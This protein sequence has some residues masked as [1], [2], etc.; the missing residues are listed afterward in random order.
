M[1]KTRHS[2]LLIQ[3]EVV[4]EQK[5]VKWNQTDTVAI[6]FVLFVQLVYSACVSLTDRGAMERWLSTVGGLGVYR[7]DPCFFCRVGIGGEGSLQT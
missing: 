1:E 7:W 4:E 3:E 2:P 5:Q 6:H